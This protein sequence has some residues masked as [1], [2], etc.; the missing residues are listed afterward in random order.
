[1][2]RHCTTCR[3]VRLHEQFWAKVSKTGTC[4]LWTGKRYAKGYGCVARYDRGLL[5]HRIAYEYANGPIPLGLLVRHTCDNPPCVNPSHLI[6]GTQADNLNDA[7]DRNRFRTKLSAEMVA[8][9][10]AAGEKRS[11]NDLA[12]AYNVSKALIYQIVKGRARRH[13]PS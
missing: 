10:R 8:E 9:I 12:S 1:M 2:Q 4:W 5:A 3:C 7:I 13:L 11:Y 6:L